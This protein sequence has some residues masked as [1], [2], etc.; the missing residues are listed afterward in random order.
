MQQS[1]PLPAAPVR[2]YEFT[3]R[4]FERTRK[5]IYDRVGIVLAG[6]KTDM[7]YSRLA[8]RLRALGLQRFSDYLDRVE[9]GDP[10]ELQHFT[11]AL[12]TNL[13]SFFREAHHFE[14]LSAH[15]RQLPRGHRVRIWSSASSTGEE[16]YTLAMT[17]IEAY[18]DSAPPV[19]ILATDVDTQVLETAQRG[20]YAVD[21]IESLSEE[22]RKRFF[23][24]GTGANEGMC[25][26]KDDVRALVSF[27]SFNLLDE[28]WRI[29]GPFD[30]I[31]C[32][33]VMIYF[34][35]QTQRNILVHMLPLL[36]ADGL[37]FAGH[38]ES[39]FHATDLIRPVG[40]TVYR[41]AAYRGASS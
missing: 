1:M 10:E 19:E 6:H 38:S 18:G 24:R 26:V 15:L 11:N 32:R 35:K 16:P 23:L 28:N 9:T 31:F 27:E 36:A 37:W 41:H 33:N 39:F 40:R 20:V 12:T 29:R 2:D 13:T 7:V 8:R 22:R 5:L 30:A 25:R 4:D 3:P 14:V 21:R 34:D 17:A